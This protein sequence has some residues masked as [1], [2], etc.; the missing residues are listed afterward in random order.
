MRLR[1]DEKMSK[2]ELN[3]KV[4]DFIEKQCGYIYYAF[5]DHPENF[6]IE[7]ESEEYRYFIEQTAKYLKSMLKTIGREY[8]SN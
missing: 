7:D 1:I 5:S 8:K 2:R 6:G 4:K 3:E